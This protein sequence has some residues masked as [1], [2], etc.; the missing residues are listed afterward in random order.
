MD[1]YILT[2]ALICEEFS[3]SLSGRF[4]PVEKTPIFLN[5]S[6][7]T[8]LQDPNSGP[9]ESETALKLWVLNLRVFLHSVSGLFR[10]QQYRCPTLT[11][12]VCFTVW[13]NRIISGVV[14]CSLGR[15]LLWLITYLLAVCAARAVLGPVRP[16]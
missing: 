4:I 8:R 14:V 9:F 5:P 3:A 11:A 15:T 10:F 2:W 6:W 16:V 13:N 7:N 12:A 1:V